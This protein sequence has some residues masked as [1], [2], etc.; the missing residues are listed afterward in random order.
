VVG[1]IFRGAF[2][3][4]R[5][6][7]TGEVPRKRI[8]RQETRRR[9]HSVSEPK[10]AILMTHVKTGE[11]PEGQGQNCSSEGGEDDEIGIIC[12]VKRKKGVTIV[13]Q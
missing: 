7:S 3:D 1:L 5:V 6:R 2:K 8:E 9:K 4:Q 10:E 12:D 11:D 13:R